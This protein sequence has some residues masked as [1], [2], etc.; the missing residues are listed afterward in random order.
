M[1]SGPSMTP[2][3][4]H[5]ALLTFARRR[6]AGS[7]RLLLHAAVPQSLRPDLLT[8]IKINFV[9]EADADPAAVADVR[10]APF[11]EALGGYYVQLD[12]EVRRQCLDH[13]A[14]LYA[15][16]PMPREQRVAAFLL[17]FIERCEKAQDVRRDVF[18]LDWLEV[19]RWVAA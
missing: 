16:E 15:D 5:E 19:Q 4:A 8:L 11:C 3:E 10:L 6:G 2:L 9:P 1:R 12:P 7:L 14:D 13:L 18:L 17:A